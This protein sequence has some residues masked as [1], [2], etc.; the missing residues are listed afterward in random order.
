MGAVAGA[1]PGR[2][3]GPRGLQPRT[4]LSATFPAVLASAQSCQVSAQAESSWAGSG[5]G[6][7]A[8]GAAWGSG[9]CFSN[10]CTHQ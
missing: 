8:V 1:E 9:L 2:E 10:S 5:H 3:L 7:V 4:L 6:G